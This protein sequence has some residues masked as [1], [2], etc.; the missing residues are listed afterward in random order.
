MTRLFGSCNSLPWAGRLSTSRTRLFLTRICFLVI[1]FSHYMSVLGDYLGTITKRSQ[2]ASRKSRRSTTMTAKGVCRGR[3]E[4]DICVPW[5]DCYHELNPETV[6][7]IHDNIDIFARGTI[8]VIFARGTIIY[9][10]DFSHTHTL[11][12]YK[13]INQQHDSSEL[14]SIRFYH[15]IENYLGSLEDLMGF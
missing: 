11:S 10:R 13:A 2:Q 1:C 8:V 7:Y 3:G 15:S 6:R 9:P 5:R 14:F 12:G 4:K